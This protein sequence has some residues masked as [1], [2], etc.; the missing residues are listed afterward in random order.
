MTTCLDEAESH[1]SIIVMFIPLIHELANHIH[2][3]T[4]QVDK[5]TSYVPS[6]D[7]V[8]KNLK[9]VKVRFIQFVKSKN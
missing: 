7:E 6:K 1:H 2:K 3:V 4:S 9:E 5:V 8:R